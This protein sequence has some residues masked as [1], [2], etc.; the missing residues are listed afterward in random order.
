[1]KSRLPWWFKLGAKLVLARLPLR[2]AAWRRAGLF[3]HGAMA[4]PAYADGVFRRHFER[5]FPASPPDDFCCLEL[6][7]GDSLFSALIARAAGA[8]RTVLVDAGRFAV[9]DVAPY[10]EMARYLQL[11]GAPVPDIVPGA[12]LA[13]VLEACRCVY[14]TDGLRSLESLPGESVDW[15]WSQAVLEHIRAAEFEPFM[16]QLR[17]IMKPS[18]VASHR[19]DLQDHLGGSLNNLRFSDERWESPLFAGSGFYTNRIRFGEMLEIFERSGFRCE[20]L[21]VDR[22]PELPIARSALAPRF[23]S[24]PDDDLR[25][26]GFDVL[27]RPVS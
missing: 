25:V 19:V 27:L 7:P 5:S 8:S 17:R 23:R 22:W 20:L 6:G 16:R 4:Q 12:D 13:A 14:L 11:R 21:Q 9:D 26:K 3:L 2:Y 1:M 10:R 15:V 18:A 24:L